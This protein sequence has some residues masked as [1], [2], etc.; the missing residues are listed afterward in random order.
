[1]PKLRTRGKVSPV[2]YWHNPD[3]GR[4]AMT[5]GNSQARDKRQRGFKAV[6][7][8]RFLELAEGAGINIREGY[9]SVEGPP[10]AHP[11]YGDPSV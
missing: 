4:I 3:T 11:G 10:G 5:R 1:M 6:K 8:A 7:A 2:I 9:G